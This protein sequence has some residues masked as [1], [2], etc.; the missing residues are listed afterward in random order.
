MVTSSSGSTG[1]KTN[2]RRA[3]SS[4]LDSEGHPPAPWE[5]LS[6]GAGFSPA[7]PVPGRGHA[8]VR[9]NKRAVCE[10]VLRFEHVCV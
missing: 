4:G 8:L 10:F 5:D 7:P 2:F 6:Q 9:P 3:R 1:A